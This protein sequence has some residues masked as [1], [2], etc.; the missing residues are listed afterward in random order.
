MVWIVLFATI[1]SGCGGGNEGGEPAVQVD[2]R[3]LCLKSSECLGVD[4]GSCYEDCVSGYEDPAIE[5]L[6]LC[7]R[8]T[9]C[10]LYSLCAGYCILFE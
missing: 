9:D 5:C 10:F 2:C 3:D 6:R 8:Q 7:D 1:V 4:E